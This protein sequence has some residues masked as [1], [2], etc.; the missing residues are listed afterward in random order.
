LRKATEQS[1][2]EVIV[3]DNCSIDDPTDTVAAFFPQAK[4]ERNRRNVGFARACNQAAKAA[5]GTFLLFLNPDVL[6]DPESPE[7]LKAVAARPQSGLVAGRLRYPDGRFQ[8]TCRNFPRPTN[9][10]FSRGSML[11]KLFGES[12]EHT[13]LEYTLPD[14]QQVTQVP[15]VAGTLLMMSKAV[16]ERAGG[17]DARYFMF[18]EDTDLSLRVHGAGYHNLF[19]PDGGGVHDWGRGSGA[20]NMIRA[21]HHHW[22]LWQYFL[23][24]EANGF[25]LILLPILLAVHL[26]L[27]ILLMPFTGGHR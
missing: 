22:S 26:V 8:A 11:T 12:V 27:S 20:G 10:L 13:G 23:K 5:T 24:H 16:F 21:W 2:P 9:L 17:F 3:V 4:I 19:V 15:A 7:R 14:Y 25:S 6:L 1:E 18:M